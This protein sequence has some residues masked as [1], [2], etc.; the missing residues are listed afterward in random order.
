MKNNMKL[1]DFIF[2]GP[3][4]T[5]STWIFELLK[6]HPDVFVPLAKDIYFFDQFFGKG[7][8]WYSKHFEAA[9]P[10]QIIG[11][12]SH[13][14]FSSRQAIDRIADTLPEAKILCCLRD[15]YKRAESSYRY[16]LRNGYKFKDFE[17]ALQKHPEIYHEGLYYTHLSHIYSRFAPNQVL[18]L[19]FDDLRRDARR[20]AE[21]IFEFLE[22]SPYIPEEL[23]TK[24]V[25][26]AEKP[27]I[28]HV[29]HL[30]KQVAILLRKMGMPQLV[31]FLKTNAIVQKLLFV[32][33]EEIKVHIQFPDFMIK[34]YNQELDAL[35]KLLGVNL[36][37][38]KRLQVPSESNTTPDIRETVVA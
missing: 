34:E 37:S 16:F 17:E 18:V 14:Y 30:A 25:N 5:G 29:T 36:T 22:I 12:L 9:Q 7:I 32:K 23:L 15:P 33:G 13:D 4:K 10:G 11:E 3:S 38:W 19:N 20:F 2:I 28:R 31:G 6:A 24:K 35:E 8:Q 27:R 21:S 1:P 26:A